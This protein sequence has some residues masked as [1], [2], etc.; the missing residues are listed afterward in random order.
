MRGYPVNP[1][2]SQQPLNPYQQQ[3]QQH[4]DPRQYYV[5]DASG[6]EAYYD[7][8]SGTGMMRMQHPAAWS[9]QQERAAASTSDSGSYYFDSEFTPELLYGHAVSAL[10][11]DHSYECM[12]LSGTTQTMSSTRFNAHRSSFLMTYTTPSSTDIHVQQ[13]NIL[14][15][16]VAGHPEASA[17]TLQAVYKTVYGISKVLATPAMG[18]GGRHFP[19]SHAY[20]PPYGG[21]ELAENIT[22][23]H[24]LVMMT[25]YGAPAQQPQ[26]Q[27]GHMGINELLPLGEGY[28]ASVSPSAVRIHSYGGLQ[29]NDHNVE[30]MLSGSIHPH[31]GPGG[32]THIS[33]GGLS[34]SGITACTAPGNAD[35]TK[36]S[37]FHKNNCNIHTL[38][39]WQGLRPVYSRS[40]SHGSGSS[41]PVAATA[42]ATSHERGSVVAGCTDGNIRLFD[43]SLRELAT[44]KSHLGGVSSIA[45]SPDGLLIAT[46]GY[47]SKAKPTSSGGTSTALYAF[48]DPRAYIYDI[49]YL[50]RG[51]ISH[52][53]AGLKGAP[54]FVK[55]M[56]DVEGCASNRLLVASGKP[57]GGMQIITPF[58]P[59]DGSDTSFLLPQLQQG[60]SMTAFSTPVDD[61]DLL[62]VGTSMGR[63]LN[64]RLSGL[65]HEKPSKTKT[66]TTSSWS[67][68][69]TA[70]SFSAPETTTSVKLQKQ[71]LEIPD[72]L[73]KMPAL[74]LDP[75]LLQGDPNI[76]NGPEEM[77]SIFGTYILL[78]SL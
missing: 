29:L 6:Q 48:P 8:G 49:R 37:T 55:F 78:V 33:V 53:F 64:F 7:D 66:A 56:P 28:V 44:I 3:Q 24:N 10:A 35:A 31:S 16:S 36:A 46:T 70:S 1:Y 75:T 63:V 68:G 30:G 15:S 13:G 2:S 72:F 57:G 59:T 5:I 51:G 38:D 52:P 27:P 20:L 69:S 65:D 26:Q 25:A 19:P 45:V 47:S 22:A 14:F 50:G 71:V 17:S 23:P 58:D 40:F 34:V 41:E 43:G 11:Y 62:A 42:M 32:V 67:R 9:T 60:E 12:Y 76:R 39:L 18:A 73:P 54:R 77:R 74:S 21:G 4:G 61:G